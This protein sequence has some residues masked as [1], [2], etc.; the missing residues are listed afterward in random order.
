MRL[1]RSWAAAAWE[2]GNRLVRSPLPRIR[3]PVS[4]LTGSV[5]VLLTLLLPVA[6]S[7]C[8]GGKTGYEFLR[9][10]GEWLGLLVFVLGSGGARAFYAYNMGFAALTFV[11][12]L[13]SCFRLRLWQRRPWIVMLFVIASV[14]FFLVISDFFWTAMSDA[15]DCLAGES[16]IRWVPMGVLTM[17]LF[18]IS[19]LLP[20]KFWPK[21]YSFAW[22]LAV[23]GMFCFVWMS[24]LLIQLV[25]MFHPATLIDSLEQQL[26]WPLI[27]PVFVYVLGPPGL[28]VWFGF[29][30]REAVRAQWARARLGLIAVYAPAALI[31]L[32]YLLS[33]FGRKEQRLWGLLPYFIGIH[34]IT[35]GYLQLDR[36]S[37]G[38]KRREDK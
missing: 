16:G 34:L 10:E 4:L 28:W 33:Q 21:R 31:G 15:L 13:F 6:Y 22:L 12:V 38:E 18:F 32:G 26:F 7:S 1:L 37:A 20:A 2:R 29:S 19:S 23:P 24:G 36:A 8:G 30:R 25:A 11:L 9:G 3:P 35:L 5:L 14:N 17:A 27:V